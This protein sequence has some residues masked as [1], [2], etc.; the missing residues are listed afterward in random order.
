MEGAGQSS[1]TVAFDHRSGAVSPLSVRVK[2]RSRR[3]ATAGLY[4]TGALVVVAWILV[5]ER[6]E[7]R[8]SQEVAAASVR[9]FCSTS[10]A[11]SRGAL[12]VPGKRVRSLLDAGAETDADHGDRIESAPG[13]EQEFLLRSERRR[14]IRVA[15]IEV[16]DEAH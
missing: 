16:G 7:D 9:K 6:G 12:P 5:Q 11:V 3:H 14:V 4:R 15:G 8:V 13:G 10:L 1:M 2:M